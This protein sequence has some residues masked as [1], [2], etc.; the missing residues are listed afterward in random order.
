M[1]LATFRLMTY[2]VNIIKIIKKING[3]DTKLYKS[4]N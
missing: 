2:M 3:C 4:G 1:Q